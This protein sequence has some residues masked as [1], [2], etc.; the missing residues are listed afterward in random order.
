GGAASAVLLLFPEYILS[1]NDRVS[2]TFLPT[3]LFVMHANLIRDQMADDLEHN[4]KV[5]YSRDWLRRVEAALSAEVSK[6]GSH[7]KTLGF[8]P[9]Y[10][11]YNHTSIAAQLRNEFG[12]DVSGLCR[13]YRF[14]YWRIWQHRPVFV[15]K[16]IV[17][18]LRIFYAPKC[19]A[20][21]SRK[22]FSLGDEYKRGVAS[23]SFEW[24]RKIWMA[25]PPAVEF[26]DRTQPLAES[27]PVL[28]Q[29]AYI[30]KPL[31][32][33]AA[34]YLPLLLITLGFGATILLQARH[35]SCLGWL[36]ASVLFAYAYSLA[37]CLEVA[38]IHSLEIPR[39]MTVQIYLAIL[40][41]FLALWLVFE[42]ALEMLVHAKITL[43]PHSALNR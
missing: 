28:Q 31:D 14:Y 20:Y 9:D 26:M 24:Y 40:A 8:D 11:M 4:A 21:K 34:T 32:I 29:R 7:Y 13:F 35:R 41:Q 17:R 43:P 15:V 36:T 6:F 30:R 16:K 5:P 3:T 10:L 39:Y 22:L 37:S 33:L 18:Q 19:G 23:L 2:Q 25:Y 27:R 42:F 1:R 12:N 38:T